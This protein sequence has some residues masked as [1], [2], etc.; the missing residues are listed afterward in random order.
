VRPCLD[1]QGR[2]DSFEEHLVEATAQ[3]QFVELDPL[4]LIRQIPDLFAVGVRAEREDLDPGE[5][6]RRR[7]LPQTVRH[8]KQ[9][10]FG[11]LEIVELDQRLHR[12]HSVGRLEQPPDDLQS[13]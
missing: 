9:P 5:A 3:S 7:D 6:Q 4:L 10:Q 2:V 13:R 1:Q 11:V 12:E 8:R